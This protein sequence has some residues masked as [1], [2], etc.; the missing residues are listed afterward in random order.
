MRVICTGQEGIRKVQYLQA[1]AGIGKKEGENIR[2]FSVGKQIMKETNTDRET[3]LRLPLNSLT[4]TRQAIFYREM[5]AQSI[6]KNP[7]H[8][9]IDTHA[10]F[11]SPQSLFCA[12]D[13][14]ICNDLKPKF[15]VVFLDNMD[16]IYWNLSHDPH[17]R[18]VPADLREILYLRETEILLTQTFA[19]AQGKKCFLIPIRHSPHLLYDLLFHAY[20]PTL[21][22]SFPVT[23]A[24]DLPSLQSKIERFRKIARERFVLFNPMSI[25]EMRWV[26]E[27]E[28]NEDKEWIKLPLEEYRKIVKLKS[29]EIEGV[30]S[31]IERQ[32]IS[33]DFYLIDQCQ[34]LLGYFPSVNGKPLPSKGMDSE[35]DYAHGTGKKVY[36]IWTPKKRVSPWYT[37]R[38]DEIFPTI[39]KAVDFLIRNYPQK[40]TG[41]QPV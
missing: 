35:I 12:I 7:A 30:R 40:E 2:V 5:Y 23:L 25:T 32:I 39:E 21:Y 41:I 33:R 3:V 31:I 38:A 15:Y 29:K 24:K 20:K 9:L 6:Q 37:T 17:K 4:A 14:D 1:V 13:F 27:L 36:L 34:I 22:A 8:L 16:R 10:T 26:W 28:K 18:I 11:R 19:K